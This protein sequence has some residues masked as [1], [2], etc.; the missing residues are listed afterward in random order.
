MIVMLIACDAC[1]ITGRIC[2]LLWQVDFERGSVVPSFVSGIEE[3]VI[4]CLLLQ[5]WSCSYSLGS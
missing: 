4:S 1:W 5:G 2:E 3:E